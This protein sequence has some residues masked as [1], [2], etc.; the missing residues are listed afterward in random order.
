MG[1]VTRNT[2]A[3]QA[4]QLFTQSL[5]F[6]EYQH[7]ACYLARTEEFDCSPIIKALWQANK[8]CY[9]PVLCSEKEGHL[10]FIRYKENDALHLNRFRILEP[11]SQETIDPQK[12]DVV[13]LPLVGFDLHGHRLGVGGGYYDRTFSFIREHIGTKPILIGLA[14]E[15]Q[16][17]HRL[18]FDEW[19][20]TLNGVVTEKRVILF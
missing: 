17:V 19:D 1:D 15:L 6:T 9:L 2:A 7:F 14:Y 18:P 5:L 11:D 16:H 10:N 3:Q 20:V 13:L 8:E 12:L 4:L